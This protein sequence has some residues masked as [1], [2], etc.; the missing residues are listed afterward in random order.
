L[1][2]AGS[3]L[4]SSS[5]SSSTTKSSTTPSSSTKSRT[6]RSS[7]TPSST[8]K[9]RTPKSTTPKST[10]PK[11]TT[12]KSTTPKSTTPKSSTPKSSTPK[13]STPKSSTPKSSTPK[14]ST[15][16][17]STTKSSTTAS[18]S[19]WV[20]VAQTVV[21]STSSAGKISGKAKVFTQFSA[22]GRGPHTLK[23]PMSAS[24]FR[25]LSGFGKPPITDGYAVWSLH[26]SGPTSQRTI[27]TFPTDKLPLQ[28]S[29]AYE[30]NGK[31]MNAQGIVGKTGELKVSYVITNTT[32]KETTVTFKNVF[33]AEEK[34]TVKAPVPIATVVNVTIPAGFTN[35]N[36][37]GASASGNGNGTSTASWTLFLFD[38][39]G[40]TK[41]S[42]TYE[43]HVTNAV[44]PSATVE[45]AVAPPKSIK[46]L[47]AVKVPG[48]PAVP[49]VTLGSR[50][51][52]LQT[53]LQ[54]KLAELASKASDALS[55]FKGVAVP[56]VRKVS[57]KAAALA[58]DLPGLSADA[59]TVSTNVG[60]ASTGLAQASAGAADASTRMATDVQA[61]LNQAA[62]GAADASTRV[63]TDV[64]AGLNRAAAGA[65][66]AST[67]M[68]D[69]QGGLNQAAAGAADASTRMADVQTG[70][71]QAAA[72]AADAATRMA[73]IQTGLE[74]LPP[75]VQGTPAY[76]ALHAKVVDLEARLTAHAAGLTATAA[77][78]GVLGVRLAA[79]GAGLTAT[80][81][82]AG[83]LGAR[84]TALSGL[85]TQTSSAAANVLGVRLTALSGLLSRTSSAAANVVRVRL[86]ALSGL[87][88]RTSS[89]AAN[90]LAPDAAKAST[91]LLALVPTANDL[92]T[93]AAET[94][95]TLADATVSPGKKTPKKIQPKQVGGGAR[96]DKAV[97]QLD[98]SITSA[99]NKVDTYYA[100]LTALDKR[101]SDN[102]LPAGNAKGATVQ[103]GAFVYSVSGANNNAHQTHLAAFIGGFALV[104]GIGFGIALYRIRR[105]MPSSMAPPKSSA[106]PAKG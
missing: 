3:S 103:A 51:A 54:G 41:Q 57:G 68:G 102:M 18:S 16:S 97:G 55:K 59:Q 25:N 94:A 79:H 22:N 44:V 17:S 69:V 89:A 37:P 7:T 10:T 29:A 81:G 11:S 82:K 52:S 93:T 88:S 31:K 91:K 46:P 90:V 70:L 14:S 63:A 32:T 13:S 50:L 36:A 56:A 24:G 2:V 62:A 101:S 53:D 38:P 76:V 26:L 80:A 20:G 75:L 4:T 48:A 8:T 64:Q 98:D 6:P 1:A 67:R 42:V 39:L 33:G 96:L 21:V 23:V 34:T 86:T 85:L 40:G 78:A 65:A 9:S 105:G 47:P 66:D 49:S 104:L 87:L 58:G 74:A 12:P 45:A 106:A 35:L 72:Q 84:L 5:T 43:A 30:L 92:S 95:N 73:D 27:A 15:T 83:V 61:G 28:V 60:N 100:N 71:N 99:G 77:I 19:K